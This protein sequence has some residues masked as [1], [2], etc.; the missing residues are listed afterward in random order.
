M[1]YRGPHD[2]RGF[3]P[4]RDHG[5]PGGSYPCQPP[6]GPDTPAFVPPLPG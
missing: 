6:P 1:A 4:Q 3:M 2:R 5:H